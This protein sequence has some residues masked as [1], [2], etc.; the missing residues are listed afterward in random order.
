MFNRVFRPF[1]FCDVV[2]FPY[3]DQ[4]VP[5]QIIRIINYE[6]NTVT[7]VTCV[8]SRSTEDNSIISIKVDL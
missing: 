2:S 1:S 8:Y 5:T 7:M 6:P 4:F 3:D